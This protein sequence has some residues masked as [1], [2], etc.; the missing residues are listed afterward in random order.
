MDAYLFLNLSMSPVEW[1]IVV[2]RNADEA[3]L[4]T[5]WHEGTAVVTTIPYRKGDRCRPWLVAKGAFGKE[6][7]NGLQE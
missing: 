5:G 7:Q 3:T 4:L 2:A 1:A 6:Q